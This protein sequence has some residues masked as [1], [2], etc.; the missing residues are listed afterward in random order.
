MRIFSKCL[1]IIIQLSADCN[2]FGKLSR[3][4]HASCRGSS[5]QVV[6]LSNEAVRRYQ[7]ALSYVDEELMMQLDGA[8]ADKAAAAR[9]ALLL[10]AAACQLRIEDWHGAAAHCQEVQRQIQRLLITQT[11]FRRDS[12]CPAAYHA[13]TSAS[14]TDMSD[15]R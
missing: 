8:H 6:A 2:L 12:V 5:A 10:N 7:L 15:P 3:T 13:S 1:K 4:A 9:S 11:S 14:L